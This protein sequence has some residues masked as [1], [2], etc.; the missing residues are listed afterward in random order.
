MCP[1]IGCQRRRSGTSL[2][3]TCSFYP[4]P[5]RFHRGR[6]SSCGA[7]DATDAYRDDAH[8]WLVVPAGMTGGQWGTRGKLPPS[9][10]ECIM[11]GAWFVPKR[12]CHIR[13]VFASRNGDVALHLHLN[14]STNSLWSRRPFWRSCTADT[15][16]E[17]APRERLPDQRRRRSHR[18]C[19]SL[20]ADDMMGLTL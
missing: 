19:P 5:A 10:P 9:T 7:L 18:G 15:L 17:E 8:L 16:E 2:L 12:S 3:E 6:R 13:G 4:P 11:Y 1:A 14:P 20:P